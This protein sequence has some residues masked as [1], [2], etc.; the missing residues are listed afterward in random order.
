[1]AAEPIPTF[2]ERLPDL[3][4][5]LTERGSLG[6]LVLDATALAGV[7]DQY[8]AD[9]FQDVRAR[10]F[11]ILGEQ[12]GK[13]YRVG[14]ILTLDQPRGLR[15]IFFL[16]RKRR[17]NVSFSASDLRAVRT[18]LVSSLVPS[19]GR[20]GFPYFKDPERLDVG[21]GIALY[22][23]L[24][25]PERVL[26]RAVEQ[27]LEQAAHQRKSDD[28]ATLERL[29]DI[30]L[31]ERVSTLYQPILRMKEGTVM[32]FEAL[33][34]GKRGTGLETAD[35]LFEAAR[36]HNLSVEL[37]RLCRRLA[38]L[39]SGRIPSTAKIFVNT[40]PATIRDPEFRGKPLIDFLQKA[41]VQPDRIVIEITEG[42]VIDNYE[43]FRDT[44][45]YFTDLNMA[46]AVDDVGK[47]YSGLTTIARLKPAFL[48]IDIGL[49]RGV[50]EKHENQVMVEAII[51]VGHSIGAGVIAEGIQTEEETQK[52]RE[53]GVDYGQ[54]YYLGRGESAPE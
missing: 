12:Q 27:A 3:E 45:G 17:R 46:F 2:H 14:D 43:M 4:K 32:A 25:H 50:H 16:E 33:S 18:R 22:N 47:G 36:E 8:G 41:Q 48:K 34:R 20:V 35:A 42:L 40:V 23:P 28:L 13:D 9:I 7:E 44:M 39:S 51:R 6:V 15:F 54:G 38:L 31:R 49:V 10:I 53:M 37:D 26:R 1:V 21:Y 11:K 5:V 29:Q 30:I 52:L 19:I 24:V